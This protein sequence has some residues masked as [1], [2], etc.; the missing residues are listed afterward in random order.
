MIETAEIMQILFISLVKHFV[1]IRNT[2]IQVDV[3]QRGDY[4]KID[5][6]PTVINLL[7]QGKFTL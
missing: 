2:S 1:L 4:D 5:F 3:S 7:F 6:S